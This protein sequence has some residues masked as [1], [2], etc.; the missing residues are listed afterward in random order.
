MILP[1]PIFAD[2]HAAYPMIEKVV[3]TYTLAGSLRVKHVWHLGLETWSQFLWPGPGWDH[4]RGRAFN[5]TY[6]LYL[7]Y[8]QLGLYRGGRTCSES[9]SCKFKVY[10]LRDLWRN[11]KL[12]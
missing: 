3:Q 11:S 9:P 12:G 7:R 1:L 8:K 2:S 5:S 6:N 4:Q 10:R